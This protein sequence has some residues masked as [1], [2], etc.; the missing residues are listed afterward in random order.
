VGPVYC[1]DC[2]KKPNETTLCN[3]CECPELLPENVPVAMLWLR[4]GTLWRRDQNGFLQGIDYPGIESLMRLTDVAKKDRAEM[5]YKVQIIE[6]ETMRIAGE[7]T[8]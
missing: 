1:R 2:P 7:R 3:E 5:F 6:S 8:T 4:A